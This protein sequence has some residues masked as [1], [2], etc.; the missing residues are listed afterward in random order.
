MSERID[1]PVLLDAVLR[2]APPLGART[3]LIILALAAAV[4]LVFAVSFLLRGAWP[5]MPFMG[6]DVALL[7]WAFRASRIAARR[8][9]HVTLTPSALRIVRLA[10]R[11]PPSETIL[12]PYWVR[13]ELDEPAEPASPLI[14]RSHGRALRLGAFLPPRERESFAGALRRALGRARATSI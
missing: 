3:L 8:E 13:V 9:E 7:G 11:K 14:L 5:V 6:L 2:P 12:N 1:A 10:P 4:N